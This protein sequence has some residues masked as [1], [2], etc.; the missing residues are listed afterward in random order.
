M[1]NMGKEIQGL[2]HGKNPLLISS[3]FFAS[4]IVYGA[5]QYTMSLARVM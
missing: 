4:T 5:Y 3:G 2:L 1:E